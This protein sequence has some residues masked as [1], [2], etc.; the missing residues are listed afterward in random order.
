MEAHPAVGDFYRQ[1]FLL[2]KA[3]D[4]ARVLSLDETVKVP[5]GTFDHCLKS[6]EGSGV[7]PGAIEF[8]FYAPGVGVVFDNDVTGKEKDS[9][10]KIINE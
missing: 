6:A 1:E 3:E 9:L 8:K 7:E 5:Y 2:N 10:V 4:F